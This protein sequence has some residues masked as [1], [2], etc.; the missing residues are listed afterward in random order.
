LPNGYTFVSATTSTGSYTAPNWNIGNLALSGT[1]TLNIVAT[2]NATGTYLNSATISG[3]QTD[4][5]SGNNTSSIT[6]V[7]TAATDL[8]ITKTVNNAAPA[9]GTNVTFTLSVVNNGPSAATGVKVVDALP[10]GYTYVSNTPSTGTWSGST[11]TIGAL[12]NG[13]TATLALVATVNAT[14]PYANSATVSG[15]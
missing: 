14:G 13:A 7:P 8:A 3:A 15:S 11:W 1:A 2:V 9:V 6:P 4:P 10:A 12:A 5:V